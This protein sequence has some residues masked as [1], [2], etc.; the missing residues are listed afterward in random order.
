MPEK[1]PVIPGNKCAPCN[2][3]TLRQGVFFTKE[4]AIHEKRR[5]V[6][7]AWRLL[8]SCCFLIG[9]MKLT[10]YM[11]DDIV[12]GTKQHIGCFFALKYLAIIKWN[13]VTA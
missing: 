12:D 11:G 9:C 4:D 8:L 10:V 6:N 1:T 3:K 5:A 7:T 2:S 13:I